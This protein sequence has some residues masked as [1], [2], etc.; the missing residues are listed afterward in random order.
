MYVCFLSHWGHVPHMS[1]KHTNMV[2]DNGLSPVWYQSIFLTNAVILPIR[3]QGIF[4]SEILFRIYMFHSRKSI[5]KCRLCEMASYSSRPQ[6]ALNSPFTTWTRGSGDYSSAHASMWI[7]V[8]EEITCCR[9]LCYHG[10]T[11]IQAWISNHIS[12]IFLNCYASMSLFF[13]SV[14][15]LMNW[16]YVS[17]FCVV[18]GQ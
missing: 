17:V 7:A 1:V 15:V 3:P 10:L 14:N 12:I 9:P 2:S 13:K 4:L 16:L 18:F 5:W 6:C 11:L 8:H